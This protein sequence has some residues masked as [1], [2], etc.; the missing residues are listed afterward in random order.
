M[1]KLIILLLL[2]IIAN[3]NSIAQKQEF[4]KA[5]VTNDSYQWKQMLDQNLSNKNNTPQNLEDLY[6]YIG[7]CIRDGRK[8]EAKKYLKVME[9]LLKQSNLP[10]S[11]SNLY[12]S[13][14]LSYGI[15]LGTRNPMTNGPKILKTADKAIAEDPNSALAYIQEGNAYLN[16]PALFGGSKSKALSYFTQAEKLFEKSNNTAQNWLYLHL[17]CLI[18]ETYKDEGETAKAKAYYEKI[19]KLE[20]SLFWLQQQ[21]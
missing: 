3:I 17:L 7:W 12:Q 13:I 16:M 20:P 15:L 18:S 11:T 2:A 5:F 8:E 19:K 6:G 10:A 14:A 21:K 4:Y 9:Q 1:K